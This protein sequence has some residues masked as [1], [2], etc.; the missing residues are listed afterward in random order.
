MRSS[1]APLYIKIK[2]I[3]CCVT[4]PRIQKQYPLKTTSLLWTRRTWTTYFPRFLTLIDKW[5]QKNQQTLNQSI[6][7]SHNFCLKLTEILYFSSYFLF[8]LPIPFC[9]F[10]F[11]LFFL[12]IF[13]SFLSIFLSYS[14]TGRD[15]DTDGHRDRQKQKYT[16]SSSQ[17]DTFFRNQKHTKTEN[18]N[19]KKGKK[20]K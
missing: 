14:E 19:R 15:R 6:S 9:S 20:R 10:V 3:R 16:H 1:F 11:V 18:K 13:F 5:F 8:F 12:S 4:S 17:K 2:L 7:L